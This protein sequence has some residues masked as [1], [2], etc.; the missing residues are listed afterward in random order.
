MNTNGF[1]I[2]DASAGSGKTYQ[3]VKSYL[4]LLLQGKGQK[5]FRE[6]LAI[7]FTNKAVAEM[8][9]RILEFLHGFS[10]HPLPS[11]YQTMFKEIATE[12]H[13]TPEVL[14]YKSTFLLK[15]ILHNYAFFEIVTID[16]FT[17]KIVRTFAKDF[18]L[19]QNFEVVLDTD[20]LL[21]EAVGQ[22]VQQVGEDKALTDTLIAYAL[23]KVENQKSWNITKDLK[24]VG[25]LLFS[26]NHF[27]Q[28]QKL[29]HKTI[30]DFD[31]LKKDLKTAITTL[32]KGM[33]AQA[34]ES[35]ALMETHGISHSDFSAGYY[36]KFMIKISN[37]DLGSLKWDA[38]WQLHLAEQKLY[39][40]KC[41]PEIQKLLDTL[42]EQFVN[43]FLEIKK[44]FYTYK[45]LTNVYNNILPLTVLNEIAKQVQRITDV[46]GKL[47][48]AEFNKLI[49]KEINGQPAPYIYERLGERYRH[50][51]IDEFQDTS[52]MQWQNLAPLIS[53]ALENQDLDGRK[54]SLL[55][56]GD[57]KQSIYRWRGGYP[58]Q[59]VSLINNTAQPFTIQALTERLGTNWRSF[60]TIID[61]NN[62]F[63][64]YASNALQ[65]HTYQ[66][67]YANQSSQEINFRTGGYVEI[68][69]LDKK[70]EEAMYC[71]KVLDYIITLKSHGYAFSDICILVRR[72][73]E[74]IAIANYLAEKEIP[75]ISSEAL[76]LKHNPEVQ[77]LIAFL[78]YLL[79]PS[80]K[81]YEFDLLNYLCPSKMDKHNFIQQ[82]LGRFSNYL[83]VQYAL[84]IETL[85][86]YTLYDVLEILI[87]KFNLVP[88]SNA[89]VNH[90]MDEVLAFTEK[91]GVGVYEFIQHWDNKPNMAIT[92]PEH[93][94]AVSIMTVH[95]S[96]G[97]EFP[98]VI[99][100]FVKTKI[101]DK[102]KTGKLW[103]PVQPNAF[104]GL[105]EVLVNANKDLEQFSQISNQ[106]LEQEYHQTELDSINVLYV[107]LTRAV[108]GLFIITEKELNDSYASLLEGF[109][110]AKGMW[111]S[112][113]DTYQFGTLQENKSDLEAT[114]NKEQIIP[115]TYRSA[116]PPYAFSSAQNINWGEPSEELVR[117]NLIH[118]VL[119]QVYVPDDL[120]HVLNNFIEKGEMDTT[121]ENEI[122]PL[123][124]SLVY[125]PKLKEYFTDTYTTYNEVELLHTDGSLVRLDRLALK[126]K[127]ATILDYKTGKPQDHHKIQ[128]MN[129][130]HI[131][132][133]M[134][135]FVTN[136]IIVYI[137]NSI[138]PTFL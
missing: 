73:T 65:N 98:F 121:Q 32:E 68:N 90:F 18:K 38:K 115:Y 53:N 31:V 97:L 52:K 6:L 86:S 92:V 10:Q 16:K 69:F 136:K 20:A 127:E 124:K 89:H 79:V 35:L 117:G 24:E 133:K 54:G 138:T 130:E 119:E 72:N 11:K 71:E 75:I 4:V 36:P 64:R 81:A 59:F 109:L 34:E 37:G 23:E 13:L 62:D 42:Q 137:N 100:P 12:L 41:E 135:Y 74:A 48:I 101:N 129:Y 94:E 1:K 70:A 91:E 123:L 84:N 15:D 83:T 112:D 25:K 111:R 28:L 27:P 93:M 125:H 103:V 108:Q 118:A 5:N 55:L 2:L 21:D 110:N 113:Q 67:M 45:F 8:K 60:S 7:T 134:G 46:K 49:A 43:L 102:T 50:Y 58:D 120:P 9:Q 96:K 33:K 87:A 77:F 30:A 105:E 99:Y 29:Q 132:T 56:V 51:F 116:K 88:K 47:H 66:D 40:K 14:Q 26:E 114:K 95:K 106:L 82:H 63:F 78:H 57:V 128:L 17:H 3:L 122:R 76:L 61:F 80:E 104:N 39:P 126:G 44:Q 22:L 107:A 85:R 131:L 19:A